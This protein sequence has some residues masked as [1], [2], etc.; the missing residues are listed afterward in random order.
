MRS[1]NSCWLNPFVSEVL[2]SGTYWSC[3]KCRM[4]S[5]DEPSSHYI[6]SKTASPFSGGS[7]TGK[8]SSCGLSSLVYTILCLFLAQ[9]LL[10]MT[11]QNW[12]SSA[13]FFG[14]R[15]N[16][17]IAKGIASRFPL[18]P[19]VTQSIWT[20]AAQCSLDLMDSKSMTDTAS[21]D[22]VWLHV[23]ELHSEGT[24]RAAER[25]M[26]CRS[27]MAFPYYFN[28]QKIG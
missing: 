26:Y 16:R 15:H 19:W 12:Q 8:L 6:C 9:N 11:Q 4:A 20:G 23:T 7:G 18:V 21:E 25:V 5:G 2:F 3:E 17:G 14:S 24:I 1:F 13:S 10:T 22:L 27:M 28:L